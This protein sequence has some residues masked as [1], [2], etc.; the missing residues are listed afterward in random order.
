MQLVK[1]KRTGKLATPLVAAAVLGATT[2]PMVPA[3]AQ[4]Y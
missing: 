2:I 4:I 3:N 1:T